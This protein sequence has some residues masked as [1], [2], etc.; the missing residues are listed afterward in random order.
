MRLRRACVAALGAFTL[1]LAVPQSASATLG[2]FSYRYIGADGTAHVRVLLDPPSREC[3]TLEEVA[4][5]NATE[6]ADTPRNATTS[7]ATVFTEPD[8]EGDY[9]VLRPLT[10]HGSQRL[11]LRSVVFS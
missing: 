5:P 4:D 7:T 6:P 2:E 3:I 11:K 8:C 9:Y 1:L 10:G